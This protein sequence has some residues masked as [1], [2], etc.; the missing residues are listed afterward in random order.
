ML[1]HAKDLTVKTDCFEMD[2]VTFG[3]GNRTLVML[4]GLGTR[5]VKGTA[6]LL[7]YLYRSFTKDYTVYV[8]DRIR[9]IPEGYTV[10]KMAED[11][12]SAMKA[13][14]LASADVF[15]VSQGGMIA[16]YLAI[17]FPELVSGLVLGVT[18]AKENGTVRTAVENWI[19]LSKEGDHTAL[20]IDMF[21]KMY[22]EPYL[23]RYKWLFPVLCILNRPADAVRFERLAEACLTC[24]TYEELEEI[25][26]PVL[27]IG[28]EQDR[29]VTGKA[30]R[31]IAEK[32]KCRLYL[33]RGL[34]HAAYEEAKD[35][36]KRVLD[37]FRSLPAILFIFSLFS[38]Q[39]F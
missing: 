37:F 33:Y 14:G 23:R 7:A 28:G 27:V 5:G 6:I 16:Q 25:R 13:L 1:F 19:R 2:Y 31:E 18:L 38:I 10:R 3:K 29:V 24:N 32:L 26:C 9:D 36:N 4:P 35:F 30:S 17:D 8:F 21:E 39:N 15:G 34:G 22:T 20:T 11:T 12:A